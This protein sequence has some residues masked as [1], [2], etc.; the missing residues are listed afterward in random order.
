MF[1]KVRVYRY[2]SP[3]FGN[4]NAECIATCPEYLYDPSWK[5]TAEK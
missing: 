4:L 2:E 3:Q 1:T 5:N